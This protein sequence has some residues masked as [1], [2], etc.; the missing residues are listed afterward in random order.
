MDPNRKMLDFSQHPP[1]DKGKH[2]TQPARS[3]TRMHVDGQMSAIPSFFLYGE[4]PRDV[5]NHFL[6]LEPLDD[7]SRPNDWKIRSH[8]HE[9]LNQIFLITG[10]A[11]EMRTETGIFR[12]QAPMLLIVPARSIHGFRWDPESAGHVLTIADAYLNEL[13]G[14]EPEFGNLF[15]APDRLVPPD[16]PEEIAKLSN[17]MQGL[18]RELSWNAPAHRTAVEAYLLNLLVQILRLSKRDS[19]GTG[20]RSPGRHAELMA[21]FRQIVEENFRSGLFVSDYADRLSVSVSQLRSACLKTAR[22]TPLDIIQDRSLLEAK[23]RL[24]YTNMSVAEIGYALGFEDPAYFTRFFTRH[25]GLS[26]RRFRLHRY[27]EE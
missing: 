16:D 12:V 15:G 26:P 18:R 19:A 23:R 8:A 24:L 10:G 22:R 20:A 27:E 2:E 14:R 7:R 9:N 25:A 21:R 11:G 6:H 1:F 5:R 3:G 4:P 17:A 13:T